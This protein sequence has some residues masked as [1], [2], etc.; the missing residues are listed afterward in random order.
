M[1]ATRNNRGSIGPVAY[2]SF[3]IKKELSASSLKVLL[4][5][6]NILKLI[7]Q[8]ELQFHLIFTQMQHLI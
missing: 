1:M 5:Y 4:V 3:F 8:C 6:F 2:V 7:V